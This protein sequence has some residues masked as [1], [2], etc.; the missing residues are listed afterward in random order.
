MAWQ[1]LL[2]IALRVRVFLLPNPPTPFCWG[3]GRGGDWVPPLL[4]PPPA[5]YF[6]EARGKGRGRVFFQK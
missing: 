3:R 4:A 2:R 1:L 5:F 6:P